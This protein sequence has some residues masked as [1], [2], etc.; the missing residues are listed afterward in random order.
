MER[1]ELFQST[2]SFHLGILHS[3]A[4]PVFFPP[5]QDYR[6]FLQR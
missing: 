4:I 5:A 1:I 2:P 6:E 3:L